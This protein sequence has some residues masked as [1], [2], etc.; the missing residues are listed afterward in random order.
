MSNVK[1]NVSDD[2]LKKG[3]WYV[4]LEDGDTYSSIGGVSLMCITDEDWEEYESNFK[5]MPDDKVIAWVELQNV[6]SEY[7]V[8]HGYTP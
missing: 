4:L 8:S 5:N 1:N 2:D 7:L 3:D 6:F